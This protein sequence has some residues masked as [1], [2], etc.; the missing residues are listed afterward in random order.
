[1]Y[2]SDSFIDSVRRSANLVR[3]VSEFVSLKKRGRNYQALCPF[4]TEKTPSFN[5]NEEKQIFHC[6]GCGTGGDVFK[7]ITLIE[8]I[9]FPEAV[10]F[11]ANRCGI[12]IP[13]GESSKPVNAEEKE[14][15]FQILKMA[16]Q[17]FHKAL[18]DEG[19]GRAG[20]QYLL[21][22]G[23]SSETIARFQLGYAPGA[24][25]RL[26]RFLCAQGFAAEAIVQSGIARKSDQDGSYFDY[27]R[28]RVVF[29][30][31]DLSERII[32]Y[33]GRA[34]GDAVPKYLN[35][36]ETLIYSKG[37]HLFGLHL[38]KPA[39]RTSKFAILV[40][41]YMDFVV[42]Y[43]HGVCNIVASLGTGLTD[44]Q[45]KLLSR[46]T[47]NVVVNYDSDN[48]GVTAAKRSL[49]IFL[50]EGFKVNV[51]VLP[52][53]Q[54]PDTYV[55]AVGAEAYNAALRS[56]IPYLEFVAETALRG[57]AD[58]RS[59]RSKINVLN[60]VLPYLAKVNNKI[61]RAE[62]SSKI[63]QRIGLED[64]VILAELKK[65][66]AGQRLKIEADKLA[67]SE[68]KPAEANLLRTLMED[69]TLCQSLWPQ[70]QED[71]FTG[72]RTEKIFHVVLDLY[73]RR[74]EVNYSNLKRGLADEDLQLLAKVYFEEQ[75]YAKT[76]TE[77]ASYLSAIRRLRL[78][79]LMK[80]IQE[81]IVQAEREQNE[82]KLLQYYQ[83]KREIT[84]QLYALYQI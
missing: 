46:F 25:D 36:P 6:F 61:E 60:T 81:Q 29:P 32:A 35:T 83:E 11:V 3:L 13:A 24:G 19:E 2:F 43:Q 50:S 53:G 26:F 28:R 33:G 70:I 47:R 69:P 27:F 73:R 45:V 65:A 14:I 10:R 79:L 9:T 34:L 68:I 75:A 15:L 55:R 71:D 21:E 40:E 74:E 78:E 67:R 57:E 59:A 16:G 7:F 18:I 5:V 58:L 8:H 72:L 30:I 23:V 52:E 42:P 38:A 48:A 12:P 56:S 82:E 41:G 63:A 49:E 84:Q 1:M 4:H 62:Y 51:L 66:V 76:A 37:R 54:D 20:H 44:Q 77:A 31:C 80:A 22:R 39:I 64:E 17:F